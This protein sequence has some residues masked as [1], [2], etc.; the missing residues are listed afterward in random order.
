MACE[1]ASSIGLGNG[2]LLEITEVSTIEE[3]LDLVKVVRF[4]VSGGYGG[5]SAGHIG[6]DWLTRDW[7]GEAW[8][9]S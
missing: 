6:L 4:L 2:S 1:V 9:T 7:S 5:R 3:D 8:L